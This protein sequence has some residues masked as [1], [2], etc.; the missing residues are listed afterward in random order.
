MTHTSV[1]VRINGTSQS[2]LRVCQSGRF[3]GLTPW[4]HAHASRAVLV[5]VAQPTLA[6]NLGQ[7]EAVGLAGWNPG[8][9]LLQAYLTPI[10]FVP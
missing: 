8:G 6:Y 4:S 10:T 9:S 2:H 7:Q 5:G 1:C 3:A